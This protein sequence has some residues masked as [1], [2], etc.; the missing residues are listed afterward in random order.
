MRGALRGVSTPG[1]G[2]AALPIVLPQR[3]TDPVAQQGDAAD[4]PAIWVNPAQPQDSR[5]L[6]TN[7]KQ[8]LLV[9]DLEGRQRQFLATGRIAVDLRQ[10]VKLG[11]QQ[12][13][14]AVATQR[15]RRTWWYTRSRRTAR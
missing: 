15:D 10:G 14:L 2:Y 1:T 11:G 5:V 13:D 4:D 12:L 7:K 3:Q 9:Y 6:A 8:G